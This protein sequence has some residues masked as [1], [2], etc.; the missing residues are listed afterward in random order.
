MS[1]VSASRP[2]VALLLAGLLFSGCLPRG[3]TPLDE[4]KDPYFL[5][6]K[7]RANSLDFQGAI[8]AYEKALE[9]NPHSASAHKE[10]GLLYYERTKDYAAAI[11]HFE[12][13]LRLRPDDPLAGTIKQQYILESK[14]Q[15]ARTVWLAPVNQRTQQEMEELEKLKKENA[16]LRQDI[17]AL[18][19]QIAHGTP[20]TPSP[21]GPTP[22]PV[23]LV[24]NKVTLP[25]PPRQVEVAQAS[26]GTPPQPTAAASRTHTVKPGETPSS[27]ARHYGIP[28]N[29]LL[30][31]NPSVEPKR[32]RVGQTL[33]VPAR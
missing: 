21:V 22:G 30:E 1:L 33:K 23:T 12:Q 9:V 17:E 4:Q 3:N 28:L 14:R 7:S 25:A 32:M 20:V 8:E 13:L 29:V 18:K 11:Y 2:M 19:V 26:A 24:T 6:G 5:K 15:L 10:L 16:Q 27:I 31:A